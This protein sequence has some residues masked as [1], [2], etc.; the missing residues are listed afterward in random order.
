[1]AE[2][3]HQ[4][5]YEKFLISL[6]GKQERNRK[7]F[8]LFPDYP[9]TTLMDLANACSIRWISSGVLILLKSLV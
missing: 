3:A 2:C 6:L 7:I 1:M 8:T 4:R 9:T 5:P